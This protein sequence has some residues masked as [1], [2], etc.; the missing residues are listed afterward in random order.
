MNVSMFPEI[1]IG[2]CGNSTLGHREMASNQ[3][4]FQL[5]NFKVAQGKFCD[6]VNIGLDGS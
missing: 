1:M 5:N 4:I 3:T 6:V 2:H